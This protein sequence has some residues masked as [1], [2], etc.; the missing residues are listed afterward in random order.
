MLVVYIDNK[1]VSINPRLTVNVFKNY[2][3][4]RNE[5]RNI[6]VVEERFKMISYLLI[7][8]TNGEL[9]SYNK[10][11][12]KIN[13]NTLIN[14]AEML[15]NKEDTLFKEFQKLSKDNPFLQNVSEAVD[16][17]FEGFVEK[18]S[19]T[20]GTLAETL[21]Q[22][23]MSIDFEKITETANII[24]RELS[25]TAEIIK[26][27]F[28]KEL[29]DSIKE[30]AEEAQDYLLKARISLL[31]NGWVNVLA[32]E[33]ETLIGLLIEIE[34][35]TTLDRND[36]TN[37]F[38]IRLLDEEKIKNILLAWEGKEWLKKRR[39]IL[40][41]TINAHLK[42]EYVLSVPVILA[43][44]EG[45]VRDVVPHNHQEKKLSNF[46]IR[47]YLMKLHDEKGGID[48]SSV[49]DKYLKENIHSGFTTGEPLNS[50]LSRN[51]ILHGEDTEYG[52]EVNS[53]KLI[54][55]FDYVQIILSKNYNLS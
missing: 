16:I 17:L 42:K 35:N 26:G 21:G 36:V 41:S 13:K 24:Q 47:K 18:I 10:Y 25:R 2:Q 30:Y 54:C 23:F 3:K 14:I 32:M 9:I 50:D 43:Q 7:R 39:G 44:F 12:E 27:S 5:I 31:E 33:D 34:E 52:N 53:L 11:S 15:L 28:P 40:K 6:S 4:K 38:M 29:L 20:M 45:I 46:D 37:N 1:K 19:K 49:F 22:N 48:L 55:I 8:E 51:A